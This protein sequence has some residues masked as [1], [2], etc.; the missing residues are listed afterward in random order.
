LPFSS[1]IPIFYRKCT[2]A[3][4][5]SVSPYQLKNPPPGKESSKYHL[6]ASR[7]YAWLRRR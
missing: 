3:G 2:E 6:P 7:T 5:P 1:L 4:I